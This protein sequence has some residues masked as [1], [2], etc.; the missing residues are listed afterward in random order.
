VLVIRIE[1]E[2]SD[3]W[4]RNSCSTTSE[5]HAKL[6]HLHPDISVS[7][8][9]DSEQVPLEEHPDQWIVLVRTVV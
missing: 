8:K 9:L 7:G 6:Q 5:F 2:K 3:P 4:V 1:L